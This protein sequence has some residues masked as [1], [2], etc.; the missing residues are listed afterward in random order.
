MLSQLLNR[1]AIG[2][3]SV[4]YR[5]RH[6]NCEF[7]IFCFQSQSNSR[8]R[9]DW[10]EGQLKP[11]EDLCDFLESLVENDSIIALVDPLHYEVSCSFYRA[12]IQPNVLYNQ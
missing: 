9:Y 6:S 4:A 10:F 5:V 7:N 1:R 11:T 12:L 8:H 3:S 2:Y